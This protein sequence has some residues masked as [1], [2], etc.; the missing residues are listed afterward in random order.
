MLPRHLGVRFQLDPSKHH[1]SA[2]AS[3]FLF[4]EKCIDN[5]TL[6]W[7]KYSRNEAFHQ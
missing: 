2:F 5:D 3:L 7:V 1:Y 6:W 4:Y